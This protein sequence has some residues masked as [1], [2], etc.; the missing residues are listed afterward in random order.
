MSILCQFFFFL[1]FN[2][3]V[4]VPVFYASLER[5]IIVTYLDCYT[6]S[7]KHALVRPLKQE[8]FWI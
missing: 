6:V 7:L 8:V 2:Q 1:L 4:N 3:K 5:G